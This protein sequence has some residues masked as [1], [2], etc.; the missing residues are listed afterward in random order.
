MFMK[1]VCFIVLIGLVIGCQ[2]QNDSSKPEAQ[3][4][5]NKTADADTKDA[6]PWND[7]TALVIY[8]GYGE[9]DTPNETF[10]SLIIEDYDADKNF[11]TVDGAPYLSVLEAVQMKEELMTKSINALSEDEQK[12]LDQITA[13]VNKKSE[14][15]YT[16]FLYELEPPALAGKAYPIAV[17]A[18][19]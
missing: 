17:E 11:L 6:F 14:E 15:G 16:W 13:W 9:D 3:K 8:A 4:A 1:K 12:W 19:E 2:S 7:R 18:E 5:T 10:E